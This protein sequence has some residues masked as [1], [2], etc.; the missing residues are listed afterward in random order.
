[1]K[2]S[3]DGL[4]QDER[5][6]AKNRLRSCPRCRGGLEITLPHRKHKTPV[7]SWLFPPSSL[8]LAS[9]RPYNT[10]HCP[11]IKSY[12][13]FSRIRLSDHLHLMS[14]ICQLCTHAFHGAVEFYRP[15]ARPITFSMISRI[16]L[17]RRS[18][19]ITSLSR[20]TLSQ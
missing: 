20:M 6:M 7:N 17:V 3:M 11:V 5:E 9:V 19:R 10:V 16:L 18:T 15:V 13:R 14:W 12:L 2:L 8:V 1:M 4:V